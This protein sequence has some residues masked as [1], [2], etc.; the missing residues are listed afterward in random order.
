MTKAD[1]SQWLHIAD[2]LQWAIEGS[3]LNLFGASDIIE[4]GLQSGMLRTRASKV[5]Y[6]T[7]NGY[8]DPLQPEERMKPDVAAPEEL[9]ASIWQNGQFSSNF[10][11]EIESGNPVR[12]CVPNGYIALHGF[13]L[14]RRS[15]DKLMRDSLSW[16]VSGVMA[17]RSRK[18]HAWFRFLLEIV[19]MERNGELTMEHFPDHEVLLQR[20]EEELEI[21]DSPH[22]TLDRRT[23]LRYV[24]G[25]WVRM[26]KGHSKRP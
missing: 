18:E 6:L 14:N 4:E 26:V 16:D 24:E 20:L 15:F 21:G 13:Q 9:P 1:P 10:F 19:Q 7:G 5:T 11:E 3:V 8:T 25:L 22:A 23:M 17:G 2:A 12:F